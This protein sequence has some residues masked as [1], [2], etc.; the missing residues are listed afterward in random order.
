M[1]EQ[2]TGLICTF[3]GERLLEKT[4]ASLDFCDHI[5]VIDSGSTDTTLDIARNAG[6]KVI[7]H[8][9]EGMIAQLRFGFTHVTTPWV[10][11]LDQDEY[12]SAKLRTS[13]QKAL[14][15][16]GTT[17]GFYLPRRSFY[18]DR[19]IMHSGWYPDYLLRMFRPEAVEIR[20]TLPH[21]E[22]HPQGKTEK[23]SGDIIHYP[24][25]DLA[26][27]LSK[28]NAYTQTAAG[29]LAARGVSGSLF[30]GLSHGIGKFLRQYVLKLGFLDGKAG[31][32]LAVH[33]FFYAL[34]KYVRID[35]PKSHPLQESD[36]EQ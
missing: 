28:I 12:L 25:R 2:I 22:I 14:D 13:V 9:F 35:E 1:P 17:S 21:E 31:F 27:H 19:F 20:G 30:K 29:E 34:H 4:L 36:H 3:N 8:P 18:Y 5:L 10:I 33:A 6:A 24:Y 11:T 7:Y 15:H 16:P 32:L 23:L 26:E